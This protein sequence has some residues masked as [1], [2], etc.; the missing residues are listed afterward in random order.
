MA[1]DELKERV[2]KFHALQ[3]PGQPMMMHMGTSHLVSD[4]WQEIRRLRA[5][6][7]AHDSAERPDVKALEEIAYY[8]DFL[9]VDAAKDMLRIAREALDRIAPPAHVPIEER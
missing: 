9:D 8:G 2:D 6:V 7:A 4:L 3:L 1:E 5:Q